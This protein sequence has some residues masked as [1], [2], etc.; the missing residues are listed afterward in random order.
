MP[1]PRDLELV[2]DSSACPENSGRPNA[3]SRS[4]LANHR[5]SLLSLLVAQANVS[6][7]SSQVAWPPGDSAHTL[8]KKSET[9]SLEP[10]ALAFLE[11]L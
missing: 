1:L 3:R 5:G 6:T 4:P 7:N 11:T 8:T 10:E 2:G 9:G